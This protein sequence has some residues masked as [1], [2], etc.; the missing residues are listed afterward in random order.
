MTREEK[1]QAIDKLTVLLAE[2]KNVY[3]AD[4]SGMDADQTSKLRRLCFSKGVKLQV[5]KNTLLKKAMESC[6]K[7]YNEL[8]DVL[9]ENTSMM[10]SETANAP[11][12]AIV[13][14]LKKNKGAEKPLFK[15]ALVDESVYAADQLLVLENLKSKEELIGDIITLLQSPAKNVISGLQTGGN[16]LAGLMKTLEERAQ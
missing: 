9:K 7:D 16:T 6:D 10:L 15:G 3:L 13:E 5:V 2:S 14:Y 1:K 8:Y 12:K 4:I 11:A